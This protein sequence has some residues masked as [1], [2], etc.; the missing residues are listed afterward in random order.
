MGRLYRANALFACAVACGGTQ[1]PTDDGR[2]E[3]VT[4]T[5]GPLTI[6]ADAKSPNMALILG[7][8]DHNGST[9]LRLPATSTNVMV[10]AM[11]VKLGGE[12]EKASGGSTPVKLAA[13]PNSDGSV[14]VGIFEEMSGGTGAQWRAG[15]WVAAFVAANM[16]GKDLTDF[17]F[18]ASSG[19]YIDGASAS[20]LMAGGYLAAI[21]GDKIDPTV[22]MTGIINPDGT[23]GPVSDIPEKFAGSIEHG[24][25]KLGYPIGMR[26]SQ[27]EATGKMV[28]L[29]E[30]AKSKGAEAVEIS[31][32]HEAYKLLTGRNLPEAVPVA[33][34][35]MAIDDETTKALDVK[36]RE[37]QTK[38]AT[39]WSQLLQ[40]QQSGKLSAT[41]A[42]MAKYA[43]ERTEQAEKLH[44]DG[45]LPAAYTKLLAGWVYAASALET[46]AIM[47][48]VK[49]GDA[50]GAVAAIEKL[51]K[52]E[53]STEEAFKKIGELKPNTMG[54]HLLMM[55]AFQAAL[56]AWGFKTFATQQ[57]EQAKALVKESGSR[58]S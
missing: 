10:D 55:G 45:R 31:N 12:H 22:T 54:G 6:K 47:Q 14:Q 30:L 40:L 11:W 19:G 25:K 57:V 39:T 35:D 1:H 7:T 24:K 2:G 8:D 13:A 29:V 23:I 43:Q 9:L 36:Y 26:Y 50:N 34:K 41:L 53:Q 56:R 37:W 46:Y 17:T 28:D 15:V 27:S 21:I 33:E 3:T 48:K 32:I 52:V 38:Y 20:G 58:N 5:Y 44:Q 4:K 51:D 42:Q 16:L 18:S 49:A